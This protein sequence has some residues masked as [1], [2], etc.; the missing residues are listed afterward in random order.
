MSRTNTGWYKSLKTSPLTPPSGVIPV[1]WAILYVMIIASGVVY[2]K[3]GGS[4]HSAGFLYYCGAWILNLSW[5]PLF[6]TY[7][8]PDLSFG[9]I[10]CL[11][12]FI[13]LN[14]PG[15]YKVSHLAGYLLVPYLAWVSFATYLNGYIFF[16][17]PKPR[18][19]N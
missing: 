18:P 13:A 17:N 9:V 15:F 3:N 1:V 8:R 19:E 4:I 6:F 11:V 14:I 5:T 12:V 16:M 2:L 10:L 7:Q